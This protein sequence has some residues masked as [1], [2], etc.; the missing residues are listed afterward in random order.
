MVSSKSILSLKSYKNFTT[1]KDPEKSSKSTI[2][3]KISK[4]TSEVGYLF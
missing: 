1:S 2:K 3:I 4:T